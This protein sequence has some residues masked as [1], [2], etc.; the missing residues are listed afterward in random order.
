MENMNVL[1]SANPQMRCIIGLGLVTHIL[2]KHDQTFV[3][4]G[5][6]DPGTATSLQNLQ[7]KYPS[8]IQLIKC[9]SADVAGN[10]ALAAEIE[11]RHGHLDTVIANAGK[12]YSSI[13][14]SITTSNI[15]L[16]RY[17]QLHLQCCG[18]SCSCTG[19]AFPRVSSPVIPRRGTR[20]L[21]L[22]FRGERYRHHYFVPSSVPSSQEK[23]LA[24]LYSNKQ[25]RWL[26]G[27]RTAQS[28][29][30]KC[31]IRLDESCIKLGDKKDT[32]RE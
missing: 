25:R 10:A 9:V 26:S 32:F 4:A 12:S 24:T 27:W 20:W 1:R 11:K 5:A 6:R 23:H 7:A 13:S 19:G 2:E 17:L 29:T 30:R 22:A 16:R 18:Y 28:H 8:R 31:C 3:Y 21:I 14:Q 15:P